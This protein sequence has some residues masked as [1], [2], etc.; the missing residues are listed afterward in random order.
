MSI[1]NLNMKGLIQI[2]YTIAQTYHIRR[3]LLLRVQYR[4]CQETL[5]KLNVT[6]QNKGPAL[7][8][9]EIKKDQERLQNYHGLG[10]DGDNMTSN[11]TVGP[12]LGSRPERG[13]Q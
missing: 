1:K 10:G 8:K 11:Y 2:M 3:P 5:E 6:R 12:W 13:Q 9:S 4:S 7:F